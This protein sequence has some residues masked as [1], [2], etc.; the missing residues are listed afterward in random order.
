MK[1]S[2]NAEVV[3]LTCDVLII[4][5]GTAGC[6]AAVEIKE[7][8]P[9]ASVII[10]DKGNIMRSGCLAMGVNAINA[11]IHEGESVEAFVDYVKREAFGI[12]REDLVRTIAEK[13][14]EAVKKVESWG[15]VIE[16]D[17][18]GKYAKRGRWNVKIKGENI[19]EIIAK[20]AIESGAEVLNY[21]VATNFIVRDNTCHGAY[22]FSLREKRFYVIS[23]KYTIIATGGASGIYKPNNEC[24]HHKI[25]YSPFNVGS[26]YAMGIRAGAEMTSF[27]MRFIALRV[28]DALAPTGTIYL[29]FNSKQVNAL[30]EEFM[31][32]RYSEYGGDR[33]PS[34]IRVYAPTMENK[35]GRGPC[36]LDTRHL[37]REDIEKL[38]EAYFN[39]YP[40]LILYW[41]AN[42]IDLTK[43]M[44][45]ITTTEPYIVGGHA[46]AG[47]WIS[48]ERETTI[49]NLFACGDVAGGAPYKFVSGC[50]AEAMIAGREICKRLIEGKT[51]AYIPENEEVKNEKARVYS[52]LE[53]YLSNGEGILAWEMEARLQKVMDEYAGGISSFYEIREERL[54]IA[55]REVK[56]I[57]TQSRYL[58]A[59]DLHELMLCCD[60]IDRLDVAE[61]LIKHLSYRKETRWPGFQTRVDY[62]ERDDENWLKFVNSRKN[63]KTGEIEVFTRDA[64]SYR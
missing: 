17:E 39:M 45:E 20:K 46:Q 58:I 10:I 18:H 34:C 57:K 43:D 55:L 29:G 52:P 23:A 64:G 12:I 14:N 2:D 1:G 35:A 47:Y 62:P 24:A 54:K 63:L 59:R 32:L 9:E 27:E 31:K 8:L 41:E 30:G 49:K 38:K 44:V 36:Y 7:K 25:W 16:K 33:A 11:Y 60:I 21:T 50:W 6:F 42:D 22:A 53:R 15:L 48:V 4:G 26:G 61:V 56:K 51:K 5:G 19:K 13:L 40:T 28:K 3:N 37:S